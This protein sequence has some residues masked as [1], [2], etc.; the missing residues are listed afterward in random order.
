MNLRR[1]H[2]FEKGR[3]KIFAVWSWVIRSMLWRLEMVSQREQVEVLLVGVQ[4]GV[5]VR[6]ELG[7]DMEMEL[8]RCLQQRRRKENGKSARRRRFRSLRN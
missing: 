4:M 7:T 8:E 3:K 1:G 2:L 6:R 5:W